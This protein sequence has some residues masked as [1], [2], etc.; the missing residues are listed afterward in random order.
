M[1]GQGYTYKVEK[2]IQ[3]HIQQNVLK[4]GNACMH[5]ANSWMHAVLDVDARRFPSDQG[6][7]LQQSMM[8]HSETQSKSAQ[9]IQS[10]IDH[11]SIVDEKLNRLSDVLEGSFVYRS[12]KID[13][14]S[15]SVG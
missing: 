7:I 15:K 6:N 11:E 4:A 1:E 13:S 9:W 2:R 12:I 5:A 14:R 3:E 10:R 8:L